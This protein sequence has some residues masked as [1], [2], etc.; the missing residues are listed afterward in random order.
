MKGW[1]GHKLFIFH[2]PDRI[3]GK[4][5]FESDSALGL[6]RWCLP[7]ALSKGRQDSGRNNILGDFCG[8]AP[9][10]TSCFLTHTAYHSSEKLK[11]AFKLPS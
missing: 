7:E 8:C 4:A 3:Q 6:G 10:E 5:C 9:C 2:Y 11:D 1:K